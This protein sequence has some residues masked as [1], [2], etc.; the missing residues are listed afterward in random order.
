M[1]GRR[2]PRRLAILAAALL[3]VSRLAHAVAYQPLEIGAQWEYERAMDDRQTMT[4]IGG[5][6]CSAS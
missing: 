3:S 6:P 5:A 4:I 1:S 2:T